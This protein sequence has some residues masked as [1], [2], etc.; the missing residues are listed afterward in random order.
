MTTLEKYFS[1]F[2]K[3]IVG[4]DQLFHSPFGDKKIIYADWTASGRLYGPIEE[5]LVREFG[6]FVGNTHSEA[7]VTGKSMTQAYHRSHEILKQHV[8]AGPQDVLI[9][10]GFGM[11]AAVNKFQRILGLRVPEQLSAYLC[12][13]E[14]LKPVVF[15]THME[16]HSNQT[17]W[18][19]TIADV[20][21]I[22]PDDRGL[23]DMN[24]LETQLERYKHRKLMIGSFTACSNVTGIRTPLHDCAKLIHHYGGY[25]FVDF[26]ASA[27]YVDMDMHPPDPAARLDGI[28]F[29]PHKFLGGP[30]AS[31]VL[32]FN[33]ELYK[34]KIPD[35]PGGGTVDWT[36]PWGHFKFI[37]NI[38]TREDGG[39]PGFLQSIKAALAVQLKEKMTTEKMLQREQEQVAR[40]FFGLRRIPRLH[41]LADNVEDR[42]GIVS[43]YVEKIHYNLIVQLLND[44]FG[45]QSRGGCSC[46]GTYGHYLL[47][48]G[49]KKSRRITQKIDHGDLSE[50]PGWVRLSVHP[51][52]TDAEIDFIVSAVEEMVR[53]DKRWGKDYLYSPVTNEFQHKNCSDPAGEMVNGWFGN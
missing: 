12:L 19:S 43:F 52:T 11:T 36:D 26:A 53:N 1:T 34:N 30:G 28:F 35:H 23:I 17:S 9:H 49:P 10:A 46:A 37:S 21:V 24:D 25:F 40:L 45:I 31:G 32:I 22:R 3:N 39:T 33:S 4:S 6:P 38:E 27:P 51:T 8:N 42:L 14:E 29:S 50:K 15:V 48:V 13:P 16:H 41:I 44:R 18:L 47:H 20:I 5:K 7:S 2:R